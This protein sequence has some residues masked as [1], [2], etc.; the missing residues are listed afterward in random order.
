MDLVIAWKNQN[1]TCCVDKS[2]YDFLKQYTWTIWGGYPYTE[3]LGPLHHHVMGERPIDVPKDYVRDHADR[4][5]FNA[6]KN[7]MRWVSRSFNTWNYLRE[8]VNSSSQFR[9][10]C[11]KTSTKRWIASFRGKQLGAFENEKDAAI[12]AAKA[13]IREWPQWAS[14]SDILVGPD[15][16]SVSEIEIIVQSVLKETSSLARSTGKDLMKPDIPWFVHLT[17]EGYKSL[18]YDDNHKSIKIGMFKTLKEAVTAHH[19]YNHAKFELKKRQHWMKPVLKNN[20]GH[21]IIALTGKA[22]MGMYTVVD[23]DLWHELTFE[24]HWNFSNPYVKG[25]WNGKLMALHQV[26]FQLKN[27]N[28]DPNLSVDHVSSQDKL[29]NSS[30]NLR[31]ATSAQQSYNQG[32]K[33]GTSKHIGICQIK[34]GT[35]K[36]NLRH[37]GKRYQLTRFKSEG[38]AI[39]ALNKLATQ[40]KGSYARCIQ[41]K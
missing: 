31:Q 39:D 14:T 41:V 1:L 18:G 20:D 15:K 35:W 10:V 27:P 13:A 4:N 37:N 8:S 24:H 9:G 38:E 26:V 7:N 34:D 40:L 2:D 22:G 33:A 19:A 32:K 29:N 6:Q 17:R 30:L 11:Y 28:Y 36:V 12:E 25:I 3:K 5:R 23:E 16:F 21:A